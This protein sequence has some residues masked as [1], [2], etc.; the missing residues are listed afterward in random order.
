MSGTPHNILT[1]DVEEWFHVCGVGGLLAP[2]RWDALPSRVVETTDRLLDLIDRTGARATFFVLGWV[3]ERHPRLVEHLAQSG[4]DIQ[5][6][7]HTH[8]RVYE[9]T[10]ASFEEDLTRGVAALA[11]CGVRH[12]AGF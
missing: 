12:V 5:S 7:G 2:D 6:H 1:V 11:A 10:P 9:L 3:A 8:T 4:H